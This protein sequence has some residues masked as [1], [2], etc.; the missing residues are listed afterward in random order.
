MKAP[1]FG[2]DGSVEEPLRATIFHNGIMIH[3]DVW[4]YGE[5]GR[6]YKK[7]GNRPLMIQDHKGTGVSFRNVWIVPDVDYD[8]ELD[9]FRSNFGDVD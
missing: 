3:D 2:D 4:V 1:V 7:H 9:G 6:A 5:V 8:E